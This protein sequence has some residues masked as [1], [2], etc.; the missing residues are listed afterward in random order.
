MGSDRF[1]VV[2]CGFGVL[3]SGFGVVQ[4]GSDWVPIGS[5]W[6]GVAWMIGD[7]MDLRL[8]VNLLQKLYLKDQLSVSVIR[9][10]IFGLKDLHLLNQTFLLQFLI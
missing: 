10:Y 5:E 8:N 9:S 6:I 4:S 7:G 1:G 2:R 3:R